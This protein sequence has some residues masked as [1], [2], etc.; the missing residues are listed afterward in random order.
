MPL[1]DMFALLIELVL[2]I[3][4]VLTI[5]LVLLAT[6]VLLLNAEAEAEAVEIVAEEFDTTAW[7]RTGKGYSYHTAICQYRKNFTPDSGKIVTF[8][9]KIT[10]KP[11][12]A[13]WGLHDVMDAIAPDADG[14]WCLN[15]IYAVELSSVSDEDLPGKKGS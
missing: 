4:L 15:I 6:G 11:D 8:P 10:A 1:V 14:I 12:D 2:F 3:E 9:H 5:E 13:T 7:I